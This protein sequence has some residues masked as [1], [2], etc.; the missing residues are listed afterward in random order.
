MIRVTD[1][2]SISEDEIEE[3]FIRASGP[4]GQN[5]NKVASAVQLRFDAANSPALTAA[6][7]QRLKALAGRRM[8]RDGVIVAFRKPAPVAGKEPCGRAGPVDRTH[9][10]G[11]D[12][13]QTA[14]A[15]QT[16]GGIPA[17]RNGT[18]ETA[19]RTEKAAQEN[20]TCRRR[21][22]DPTDAWFPILRDLRLS[23][24]WFIR[25]CGWAGK[26]ET[27]IEISDADKDEAQT[28]EGEGAQ[29]AGEMRQ[30]GQEHLGDGQKN[31]RH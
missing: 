13:S 29:D 31:D 19:W 16:L 11:R 27:L 15:D 28:D 21:G 17:S 30:V 18:Q 2:I 10:R 4:G 8:N 5:V 26:D 23:V 20:E 12:P 22:L 9:P 24:A 7:F 1:T 25:R 6:V 3:R 14:P